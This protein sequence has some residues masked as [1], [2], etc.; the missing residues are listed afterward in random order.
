MDSTNGDQKISPTGA[1]NVQEKISSYVKIEDLTTAITRSPHTCAMKKM[2][3]TGLLIT[4]TR[5]T[6][7]AKQYFVT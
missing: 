4:T 5:F 7:K 1:T 3:R 6:T 2:L